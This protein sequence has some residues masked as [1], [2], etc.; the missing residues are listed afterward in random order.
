MDI[1][2]M[3][4]ELS[5]L[6]NVVKL[7]LSDKAKHAEEAL[8]EKVTLRPVQLKGQTLWQ[9]ESRRGTQV[10]HENLSVVEIQ[11]GL[12]EIGQEAFE[13][14]ENLLSIQLHL[15]PNRLPVIIL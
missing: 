11:E 2:T 7:T 5:G 1:Q 12:R 15:L 13:S 3:L 14:C 10:F 8:A 6:E 4:E 9:L